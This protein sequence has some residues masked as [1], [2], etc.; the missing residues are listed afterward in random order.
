M[1][2]VLQKKV[3]KLEKDMVVVLDYLREI[4]TVIKEE[5]SK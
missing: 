3:K 1:S 4:L 5:A 2:Y